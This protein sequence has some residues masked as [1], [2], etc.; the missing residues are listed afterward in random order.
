MVT[1]RD[2]NYP[3]PYLADVH[4]PLMDASERSKLTCCENF[5]RRPVEISRR[6]SA[7]ERRGGSLTLATHARQAQGAE[8]SCQARPARG[9][10]PLEADEQAGRARSARACPAAAA[11]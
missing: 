8:A 7:A 6:R 11:G 2:F 3:P 10:R 9:V 5:Y 1:R 4:V